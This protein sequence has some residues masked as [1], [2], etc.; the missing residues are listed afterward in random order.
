MRVAVLETKLD[1]LRGDVAELVTETQRTRRRLHDLEGIAGL[2]VDAGKQ[3][4][5]DEERRERKYTRRL[6]LLM[7]LAT[8]AAVASP[9]VVALLHGTP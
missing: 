6:N 3:R 9:I 4:V 8:F 5:R 1:N 2:L 7:V